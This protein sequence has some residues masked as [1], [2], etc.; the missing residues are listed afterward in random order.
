V[1]A[2]TVVQMLEVSQ[3]VIFTG[4][5]IDLCNRGILLASNEAVSN[6]LRFRACRAMVKVSAIGLPSH[7]PETAFRLGSEI[8]MRL[9]GKDLKSASIAMYFHASYGDLAAAKLATISLYAS[10]KTDDSTSALR[11]RSDCGYAF[12]LC[13]ELDRAADAFELVEKAAVGSND[14]ARVVIA[15]YQTGLVALVRDDIESALRAALEA[16]TVALRGAD[17]YMQSVAARHLARLRLLSGDV[18]LAKKDFERARQIAPGT[19]HPQWRSFTN[20]MHLG[21]A[22]AERD[23][24]RTKEMLAECE[25]DYRELRRV[26]GQEFLVSRMTRAYALIGQRERAESL[27]KTYVS[28][29]RRERYPLPR[30]VAL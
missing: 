20:A 15:K 29:D 1:N 17:V 26:I 25:A 27:L 5:F 7:I 11:E 3:S 14:L 13:G 22:V 6:V 30:F 24:E 21:I 12:L 18:S 10:I 23:T 4:D 28:V 19:L 2:E 9:E 16:D 8:A